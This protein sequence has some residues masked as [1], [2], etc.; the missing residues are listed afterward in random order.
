MHTCVLRARYFLPNVTNCTKF[1]AVDCP[2][3][4]HCTT[5]CVMTNRRR[6]VAHQWWCGL[7]P[8]RDPCMRD[9]FTVS[10][11]PGTHCSRVLP[12]VNNI[13]PL[14]WRTCFSFHGGRQRGWGIFGGRQRGWGILPTCEHRLDFLFEPWS[15]VGVRDVSIRRTWTGHSID[16][17]ARGGHSAGRAFVNFTGPH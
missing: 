1:A 5:S 3:V 16:G 15:E 6:V 14:E 4:A 12:I 13:Q 8:E 9:G 17:H 11:F 10:E 7:R 2:A